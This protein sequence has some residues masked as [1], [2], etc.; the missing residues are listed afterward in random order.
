MRKK[1]YSFK[2]KNFNKIISEASVSPD[3][4]KPTHYEPR[5]GENNEFCHVSLVDESFVDFT[6]VKDDLMIG[7]DKP[8]SE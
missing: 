8:E 1:R 2:I 4:K 7:L 6:L 3:M 5:A